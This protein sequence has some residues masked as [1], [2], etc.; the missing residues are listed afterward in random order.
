M[1]FIL[2][3]AALACTT[4]A[5]ARTISACTVRESKIE[6]KNKKANIIDFMHNVAKMGIHTVR[7]R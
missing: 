5:I 2:P 1:I 4:L 6:N 7:S 3:T